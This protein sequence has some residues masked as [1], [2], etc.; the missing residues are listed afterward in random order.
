M[1]VFL[2]NLA[3]SIQFIIGV[4][5]WKSIT[6][7]NPTPKIEFIRLL[8]KM[9]CIDGTLFTVSS[10]QFMCYYMKSDP[11]FKIKTQK[12]KNKLRTN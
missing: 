9:M 2:S 3:L 1:F 10:L 6:E 8:N 4:R 5:K 11:F 12:I 7:K